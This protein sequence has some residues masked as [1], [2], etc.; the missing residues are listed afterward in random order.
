MERTRRLGRDKDLRLFTEALRTQPLVLDAWDERHWITLVEKGTVYPD[1][2][3]VRQT[4]NCS[5]CFFV[6][7]RTTLPDM[8]TI[9]E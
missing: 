6:L 3:I 1:G 8:P 5:H 9:G 4:Q 2:G 7:S